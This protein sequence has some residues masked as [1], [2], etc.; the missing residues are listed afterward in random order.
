LNSVEKF[1][2]D[3]IARSHF[4]LQNLFS[5]QYWNENKTSEITVN[6][7]IDFGI[8]VG[9]FDGEDSP[10]KTDPK[11]SYEISGASN[12]LSQNNLVGFGIHCFL[13]SVWN[14]FLE[15]RKESGD[16]SINLPFGWTGNSIFGHFGVEKASEGHRISSA[17]DLRNG[18]EEKVV[19]VLLV[20]NSEHSIQK[21]LESIRRVSDYQL[22][23]DDNS[24]DSTLD[25]VT[26]LLLSYPGL[27]LRKI[28]GFSSSGKYI[29]PLLNT[30]TTVWRVDGDEF[31][32]PHHIPVIKRVLNSH[33]WKVST[34]LSLP[35]CSVDITEIKDSTATGNLGSPT[36]FFNF[37]NILHWDQPNERLHGDVR[38]WRPGC[39]V[40]EMKDVGV[41]IA[42]FPLWNM[43]S[44]EINSWS[45]NLIDLK[46]ERY[47]L[48]NI[49]KPEQN[50]EISLFDFDCVEE[51]KKAEKYI[52]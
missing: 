41:L 47:I 40:L 48:K 51:L 6:W 8:E 15:I 4:F 39:G 12:A 18:K 9:N 28:L 31:W 32:G 5:T 16:D 22:V 36:A 24:S 7:K 2:K 10:F 42:H 30:R 34:E 29:K 52:F 19:A 25:I 26:D 49:E 50:I 3:V 37:A 35:C 20:K 38:V 45:P 21:V 11:Y 46:R 13:D 27:I 14:R 17:V 33:E 44:Q 23:L 1:R 43:S